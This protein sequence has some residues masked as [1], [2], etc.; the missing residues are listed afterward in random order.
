[1]YHRKKYYPSLCYVEVYSLSALRRFTCYVEEVY[2][3]C[4]VLCGRLL[5]VYHGRITL[6]L[7]LYLSLLCAGLLSMPLPV[8]YVEVCSLCA[9]VEVCSLCAMWRFA[10]YVVLMWRFT[11]YRV[12]AVRFTQFLIAF[13]SQK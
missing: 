4:A 6:S 10:H 13:A 2:S 3:H 12:Y 1:M 11:P 8:C 9:N 7:S 5:P